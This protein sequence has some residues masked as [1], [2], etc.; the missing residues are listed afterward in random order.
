MPELKIK[1]TQKPCVLEI[2]FRKDSQG[3]VLVL[4]NNELVGWFACSDGAFV[5]SELTSR[6][7]KWLREKG[8]AIE[9]DRL[10]VR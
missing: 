7:Q 6:A 8:V 5:V 1:E 2:E 9:N 3:D 4:Y 10:L